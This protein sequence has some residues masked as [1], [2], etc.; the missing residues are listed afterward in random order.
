M[1]AV[2]FL[3]WT[4][5]RAS[6]AISVGVQMDSRLP[7]TPIT[8]LLVSDFIDTSDDCCNTQGACIPSPTFTL[9]PIPG[10]FNST[11]FSSC[12]EDVVACTLDEYNSLV[13]LITI[14]DLGSVEFGNASLGNCSVIANRV[15][16]WFQDE[17]GIYYCSYAWQRTI[18]TC[19]TLYCEWDDSL[20]TIIITSNSPFGQ[21]VWNP[22]V[23]NT[24]WSSVWDPSSYPGRKSGWHYLNFL[25]VPKKNK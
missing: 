6:D 20:N 16:E 9:P 11:N 23:C 12:E 25:F 14:T 15:P 10:A 19:G 21:S 7:Y 4:T 1:F 3:V 22:N 5:L 24:G 18:R 2:F 13:S 17:F 8:T